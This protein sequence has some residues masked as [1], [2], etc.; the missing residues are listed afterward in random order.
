MRTLVLLALVLAVGAGS[1]PAGAIPAQ[2]DVHLLVVRL[3]WGPPLASVDEVQ[4]QIAEA[5]AFIRRSSFGRASLSADVTPVVTGFTIPQACLAGGNE[6]A[7]L[8]ALS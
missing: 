2:G 6:D 5:D 7:G 4:A 1:A 8:G 3:T